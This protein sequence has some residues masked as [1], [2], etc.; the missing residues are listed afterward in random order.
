MLSNREL[1]DTNFRRNCLPPRLRG[2]CEEHSIGGVIAGTPLH[3][4]NRHAVMVPDT[5]ADLRHVH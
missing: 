3:D 4:F 5:R 1:Q 2:Q